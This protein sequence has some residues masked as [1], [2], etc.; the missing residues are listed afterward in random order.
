VVVDAGEGVVGQLVLAFDLAD[1]LLEDVLHRHDAGRPAVLVDHGDFNETVRTQ[2]PQE[3]ARTMAG[4]VFNAL[5]RRPRP[6]DTIAVD[7]VRLTVEQIDGLRI[8]RLRVELA[9][10]PS[11]AR[12][13]ER[14]DG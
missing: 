8:T 7:A 13:A 3:G 12:T 4:L 11:T 6:G 14:D 10:T 5:G 2:L 9:S 1:D